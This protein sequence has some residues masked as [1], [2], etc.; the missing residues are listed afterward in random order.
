MK[1]TVWGRRFVKGRQSMHSTQENNKLTPAGEECRTQESQPQVKNAYHGQGLQ[2]FKPRV[3]P[4][5]RLCSDTNQ[6]SYGGQ[7]TR[8]QECDSMSLREDNRIGGQK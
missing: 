4:K 7:Q 3:V 5:V 6:A 8:Q 1:P 2:S